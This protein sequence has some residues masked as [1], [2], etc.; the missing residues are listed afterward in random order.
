MS[1][2]GYGRLNTGSETADNG[3]MG[4]AEVAGFG[5]VHRTRL[6]AAAFMG[7]L[8]PVAV[9]T[10]T[11]FGSH[12]TVFFLGAAGACA[13]PLIVIL[14]PRRH[15]LLFYAGAYGGL[16]CMAALQAYSGGPASGY[17]VLLMMP[18]IWFGLQATDRE[19]VAAGLVLAACSYLPMLVF[20]P[21]AYPVSW[22]HAS[23]LVLIGGAVSGSLRT[24]SRETT[25]LTNRLRREAVV[26]DL[27]GLLNRRGW[28]VTARR[29]LARA[30]RAG[31]PVAL[32]TMDL[33]GLKEL[34]DAQGHEEGDR[35]LRARR[36]TGCGAHFARPTWSPGWA[37]TSLPRSSPSHGS[38]TR[39]VRSSA[40][41]PRR[42]RRGP[43]RPGW[44]PGT[45]AR[46]SSP[47]Y[48]DAPTWRSTPPRRAAARPRRSP[49]RR[50]THT[51]KQPPMRSA[52]DLIEKLQQLMSRE[53]HALVPP[54]SGP[55]L[56]R[57]QSRPMHTTKVPV[58]E[59]VPR[60]GFRACSLRE[61]QMPGAIVLPGM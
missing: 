25:R 51:R 52:A 29:E 1:R 54:L 20:G 4:S 60:L 40:C 56:T 36:A 55:V 32:V 31:M 38:T 27:T 26:D 49:R 57:N 18:L 43:S 41:R 14:V 22:G 42:L 23:L 59:A 7:N 11:D 6:L 61:P 5:A 44:P 53:L 39:S 30:S 21:P 19:L 33:D 12:R 15:R 45:A 46:S 37:A 9:A 50:S 34:N 17:S 8:L 28:E 2:A 35:V 24:L 13:A 47:T 48:C 58:D 10:A 16:P 3:R